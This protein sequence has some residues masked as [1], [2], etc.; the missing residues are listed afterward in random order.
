MPDHEPALVVNLE[1]ASPEWVPGYEIARGAD[2]LL[3]D[4]T[5]TE[6]EYLVR[7]TWGHSSVAD[8]VRYAQVSRAAQ[9]VLFHHGP[10]RSDEELEAMLARARELWGPEG[11]PL[12]GREGMEI[13]LD[14]TSN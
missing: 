6:D 1:T 8:A 5:Y 12:L 13:R 10:Y 4:S 9:L 14:S 7:K 11:A 3:H 2:V